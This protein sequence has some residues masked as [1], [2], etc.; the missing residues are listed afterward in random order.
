MNHLLGNV[1]T[2]IITDENEK[3]YFVQK[4]GK[5]FR[6]SKEEGIFKLGDA[7]QGFGFVDSRHQVSF[8]L[9]VPK[10]RF[11]NYGWGT[12]KS[13]RRD[14]GVFIDIGL[15]NKDIVISLDDLPSEKRLWP[16]VDDKLYLTLVVDEKE[17]LWGKL[18]DD[19]VFFSMMRLGD[20][21]MQNK[22]LQATVFRLKLAGTYVWTENSYVGFIHPS[23]RFTEPRLGEVIQARVIGLRS[24]KVLNLSLKPRAHEAM[25]SDAMMI[26]T[27]LQRSGGKIPYTDKTNKEAIQDAFGISKGQFK[28]AIGRLMKQK[29]VKQENGYTYLI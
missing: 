26:L 27:F 18:A 7:V 22:N 16:K 11:G 19:Q 5:T 29:K 1:F 20:V 2:G 3:Y 12:V 28:R 13:V 10:V 6:L 9:K 4:E 21:S 8:T 23:E 17:R 14:L 15:S 24:D 25:D